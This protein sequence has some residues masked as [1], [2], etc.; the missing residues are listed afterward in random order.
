MVEK[1][2][3]MELIINID[4]SYFT[5]YLFDKIGTR[6]LTGWRKVL[7]RKPMLVP[8]DRYKMAQ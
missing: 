6:V 1:N 2:L 8:T 4:N 5:A 3:I 7:A